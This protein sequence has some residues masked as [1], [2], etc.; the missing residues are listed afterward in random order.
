MPSLFSLPQGGRA[1]LLC[2][3]GYHFFRLHGILSMGVSR[4]NT[5][6][7]KRYGAYRADCRAGFRGPAPG[8]WNPAVGCFPSTATR[9]G[10][11]LD[12][13]FYTA[14]AS[15]SP[16]DLPAGDPAHTCKWKRPSTSPSAAIS[17]PIW[18]TKSTAVT[19]TACFCFIDQLPPGMRDPLY[20]KDDD[21]RLS[22]LYRQLHHDDQPQRP[23]RWSA[24]VKMHI[25]PIFIFGPHQP[26]RNSGSG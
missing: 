25:S 14:A 10:D 26:T 9:W 2:G 1:G 20:F 12:Y 18:R 15:F 4:Q 19:T 3:P 13:Q 7:R 6:R 11:A 8:G 22:F 23:A 21:E 24:F 16:D 17:R 5:E